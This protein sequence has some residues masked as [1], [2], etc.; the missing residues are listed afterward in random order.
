MHRMYREWCVEKKQKCENKK[1]H[2]RWGRKTNER[3]TVGKSENV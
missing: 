2:R 3:G 1:V